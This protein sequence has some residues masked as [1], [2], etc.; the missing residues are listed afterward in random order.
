MF[1]ARKCRKQRF[2]VRNTWV[3]CHYTRFARSV[4]TAPPRCCEHKIAVSDI[5]CAWLLSM[6]V[7]IVKKHEG[8]ERW[9][10]EKEN[11]ARTTYINICSIGGAVRGQHTSTYATYINICDIYRHM[12]H[13][14][15]YIAWKKIIWHKEKIINI[16]QYMWHM[17][18]YIIYICHSR[19]L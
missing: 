5:S 17:S 19:I 16:C 12:W 13:T 8:I 6:F 18:T 2:C 10:V 11:R 1:G 7:D 4:P 14:S 9:E 3:A 15:T